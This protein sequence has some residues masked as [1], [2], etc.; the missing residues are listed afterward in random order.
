MEILKKTIGLALLIIGLQASAQ[1]QKTMLDAFN[2]SYVFENGQKYNEAVDALKALNK[3]NDYVVNLRLGWLLY[4]GKRYEESVAFYK[5]AAALMPVA[6]EPLQ[7]LVNTQIALNKWGDV[8]QTYLAILKID[9]KNSKTN[10]YLGMMYYNRKEYSKADKYFSV[11]LNLYP[12]DYDAM[13]MS[14]WNAY[15]MGKTNEA[16]DLFHRVLL[17]SP[18][19]ASAKEGLALLK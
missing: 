10:Y 17:Y 7:G 2:K 4:N 19:D 3:P 11:I 5:K 8:E 6:I 18:T 14:A 13:L 12:Y 16:K 15:F 9:T 1:D